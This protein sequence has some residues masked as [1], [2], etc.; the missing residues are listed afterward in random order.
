MTKATAFF[1]LII[2]YANTARTQQLLNGN[3]ETGTADSWKFSTAASV[4]PLLKPGYTFTIDR[5]TSKGNSL[6]GHYKSGDNAFWCQL[7][8]KVGYKPTDSLEK[9]R[10]R[11]SVK[12]KKGMAGTASVAARALQGNQSFGFFEQ[13][14]VA[15]TAWTPVQID[16]IVPQW[17]DSIAVFCA[18]RGN[19]EF[20][21]DDLRL[22]KIGS[23]KFEQSTKAKAYLDSAIR[24]IAAN[25]FYRD[26]ID[27]QDYVDYAR[28]L[29]SDA[30]TPA[31]CYGSIAFILQ[32]LNQKDHHSFFQTA[33]QAGALNSENGEDFTMP[34]GGLI[35]KDIGYVKVPATGALSDKVVR[36]YADSL[37]RLI[38]KLDSKNIRGWIVDVRDNTGG[39]SFPMQLGLGPIIGEGIFNRKL[40]GGVV[41]DSTG[42]RKGAIRVNGETLLKIDHPYS[43]LRADPRVAVLMNGLTGSS[44]ES[45]VLGFKNRPGAKLFG[46]PTYGATTANTDFTLPDGALMLV[47]TGVQTDRSGHEYGGKIYPDVA[48][49]DDETTKADEVAEAAAQWIRSEK[50]KR[51]EKE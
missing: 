44:G 38:R 39:N 48:V 45:V 3:F 13:V 22:E 49:K 10:L 47:M 30:K 19:G 41:V 31:D 42:Y 20:W 25:A 26:S 51:K 16:F 27:F 12:F 2:L 18:L 36:L 40:K 15:D 33:S 28:L 14:L 5:D 29:A 6:V 50:G 1:V 8:Q 32:G 23:G 34:S 4:N 9:I 46:A 35:G 17:I 43:L 11:A 24:I 21:F 37:Q 7:R